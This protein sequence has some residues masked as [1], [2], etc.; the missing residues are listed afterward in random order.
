MVTLGINHAKKRAWI[1]DPTHSVNRTTYIDYEDMEYH[2]TDN[3]K[4]FIKGNMILEEFKT[5][6]ILEDDENFDK[7][8]EDQIKSRTHPWFIRIFLPKSKRSW[9]YL[10]VGWLTLKTRTPFEATASTY[11]IVEYWLEHKE[12][13]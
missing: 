4:L 10:P 12:E 8:E 3:D 9:K 7:Y 6:D 13:K 2:I 1:V 11:E 5:K